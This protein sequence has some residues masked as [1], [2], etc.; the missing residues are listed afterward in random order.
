[1]RHGV[2]VADASKAPGGFDIYLGYIDGK[3]QSYNG[4]RSRFPGK[5]IVP[6]A[7]YTSTNAG[8]VFDGPPDNGTW[9]GVVSW[10]RMRRAAGV[11]PTVYTDGDQWPVGQ[12]A[13][14]SA[15]VAEPHWWIASWNGIQT[16]PAGAIGHQYANTDPYDLSVFADYWPGVD[17]AQGSGTGGSTKPAPAPPPRLTDKDVDV[18]FLI[19]VTPAVTSAPTNNGV[20][21]FL[22]S[23]PLIAHLPDYTSAVNL[24]LVLGNAI[25]V[26]PAT[27]QSMAAASAALKG[28]LAGSLGVSG[29]LT[30]S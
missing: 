23:G 2:D 22:V 29:S 21:Y 20:D 18:S 9:P 14:K 4:L 25:A 27:Y 7:V 24:A 28:T 8:L 5:L 16:I 1:M 11:D 10:V 17:P 3:Y 15:G 26:S 13:F 30:V 19:M 12:A 6:I